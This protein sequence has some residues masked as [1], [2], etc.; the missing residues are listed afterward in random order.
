MLEWAKESLTA[1]SCIYVQALPQERVDLGAVD[2]G[3]I[4]KMPRIRSVSRADADNLWAGDQ[5]SLQPDDVT[6]W[7]PVR[8]DHVMSPRHLRRMQQPGVLQPLVQTRPWLR[9]SVCAGACPEEP[10][11]QTPCAT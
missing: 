9:L 4:L 6:V 3:I 10:Q 11:R 2:D 1:P 7:G 5:L 8:R